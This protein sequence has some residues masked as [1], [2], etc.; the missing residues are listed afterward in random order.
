MA[1]SCDKRRSGLDT[2]E[3]SAP[4]PSLAR[5]AG[6]TLASSRQIARV[7]RRDPRD[8]MSILR[9]PSQSGN[10]A[11]GIEWSFG[12]PLLPLADQRMGVG[13]IH[14]RTAVLRVAK[15]SCT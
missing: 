4:E 6:C 12:L 14:V 8:H 11:L 13:S 3:P 2:N 9:R 5:S 15:G 1:C 10:G 7:D